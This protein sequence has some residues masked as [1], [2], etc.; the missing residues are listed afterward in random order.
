MK[1]ASWADSRGGRQQLFAVPRGEGPDLAWSASGLAWSRGASACLPRSPPH[2][3][4]P[5]Q[6]GLLPVRLRVGDRPRV[7]LLPTT[8]PPA[9][10]GP[11][12]WANSPVDNQE[13]APDSVGS[14]GL[15]A[16]TKAARIRWLLSWLGALVEGGGRGSCIPLNQVASWYPPVPAAN[17]PGCE[18]SGTWARTLLSDLRILCLCVPNNGAAG[19]GA[20]SL[21]TC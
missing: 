9:M 21:A 3:R 2:P 8:L 15:P 18:Q 19:W 11:S 14:Q 13:S 4:S 20:G 12:S 7:L 6:R 16:G 17:A 10:P 1:E 5:S